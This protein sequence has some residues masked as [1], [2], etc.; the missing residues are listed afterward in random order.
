MALSI[1][2]NVAALNAYRNLNGTLDNDEPRALPDAT[3][4]Y[5]LEIATTTTQNV[6]APG[7]AR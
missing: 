7:A 2:N 1:N 6:N 3:G 4:A 5:R